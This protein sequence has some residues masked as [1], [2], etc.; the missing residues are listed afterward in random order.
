M[1]K[2]ALCGL[3]I[4][5]VSAVAASMYF[6]FGGSTGVVNATVDRGVSHA[7]MKGLRDQIA[8]LEARLQR[9][10][11][12]GV[13]R[14]RDESPERSGSPTAGMSSGGMTVE[15]LG[16]DTNLVASSGSRPLSPPERIRKLDQLKSD[17]D[18]IDL[19]L[20]MLKG[21][22]GEQVQ[23]I[24]TLL[25]LSPVAGMQA[26]TNLVRSDRDT[27]HILASQ[28]IRLMSEIDDPGL[29]AQIQ[30]LYEGASRV[31]QKAAARESQRR[32]NSNLAQRFLDD[33]R[34]DL[35]S[36]DGGVRAR[37]L[38]EV[39]FLASPQ[40]APVVLPSLSDSN[41]QVRMNALYALKLCKDPA[42]ISHIEPL[43]QDPDPQVRERASQTIAVLQ[44]IL[45]GEGSLSPGGSKERTGRSG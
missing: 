10:E 6:V 17:Q 25:K 4:A 13:Q 7:E 8:R 5:V 26:L 23:A 20:T 12:G 32:G 42:M 15:G 11:Q 29:D 40:I 28:V 2:I 14:V 21:N 44:K 1:S 30:S 19:A 45:A 34:V 3:A 38:L 43:L 24:H 27:D 31:V 18:R 35:N 22:S 39:A 37:T 16:A 33:S 41:S 9:V 36:T